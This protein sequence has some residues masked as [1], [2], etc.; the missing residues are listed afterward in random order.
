MVRLGIFFGT[1]IGALE[2]LDRHH[3]TYLQVRSIL[4][5]KETF[6]WSFFR[7]SGTYTA[8][9]SNLKQLRTHWLHGAGAFESHPAMVDIGVT[10]PTERE[11]VIL[12]IIPTL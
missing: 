8:D 11:K 12:R 7:Q 9:G 5:R 4:S 6:R 2:H 1:S 10:I 3:L